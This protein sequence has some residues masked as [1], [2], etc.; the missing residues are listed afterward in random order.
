MSIEI[1]KVIKETEN[2]LIEATNN[3]NTNVET[4]VD[5]LGTLEDT[6]NNIEDEIEI[7]N[8]SRATA[9]ASTIAQKATIA[10]DLKEANQNIA[11]I[12]GQLEIIEEVGLVYDIENYNTSNVNFLNSVEPLVINKQ[13]LITNQ[14]DLTVY[15]LLFTL[16]SNVVDRNTDTIFY[17]SDGSRIYKTNAAGFLNGCEILALDRSNVI[18]GSTFNINI[19]NTSAD[20]N[21]ISIDG[22]A[23][24]AEL[25][26]E[27]I[28]ISVSDLGGR[29]WIKAS[30]QTRDFQTFRAET[31]D[32]IIGKINIASGSLRYTTTSDYRLK[33]N[34]INL[35]DGLQRVKQIKPCRFN[36]IGD[37]TTI[38]GFIAHE[39]Q[40]I[41]PESVNGIK[42]AVDENGIPD[43]QGIDQSKIISLLIAS[44][45]EVLSRLELLEQSK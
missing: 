15:Q 36:F 25:M 29:I 16:G 30:G 34:V 10:K 40:E 2:N 31:N 41:V 35:T 12:M 17:S 24:I 45:Q 28:D 38:D 7:I 5:Y 44:L 9:Q 1:N 3:Y 42:D 6:L 37:D 23:Y 14:T 13:D 20:P 26:D 18:S 4:A 39:I 8:T 43:Y 21:N 19:I 32:A 33:E 22:R 11:G 27:T